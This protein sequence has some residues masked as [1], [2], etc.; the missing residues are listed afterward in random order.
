MHHDISLESLQSLDFSKVQCGIKTLQGYVTAICDLYSF[1]HQFQN[2]TNAHPRS[3]EV[4]KLLDAVKKLNLKEKDEGYHDRLKDT[5]LD[6]VTFSEYMR[7]ASFLGVDD[8]VDEAL[9][10]GYRLDILTMYSCMAR[11]QITRNLN[12]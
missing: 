4:S 3:K 9:C 7:S 11:S 8:K 1:Q 10:I 6:T 2:N 5:A 12:A